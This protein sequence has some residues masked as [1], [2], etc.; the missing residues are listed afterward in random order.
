MSQTDT[1]TP[2]EMVAGEIWSWLGRRRMSANKAAA[3]LGWK[4][5]YLSRRLTGAVPFSVPELYA[6][7]HLLDVPVEQFFRSPQSASGGGVKT[8]LYLRPVAAA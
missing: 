7:A 3:A 2:N 1:M 8:A 6:L 5:N 4:Q